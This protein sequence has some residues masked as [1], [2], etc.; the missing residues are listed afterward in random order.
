MRRILYIHTW[1]EKST[2]AE[3]YAACGNSGTFRSDSERPPLLKTYNY[4][5][6]WVAVFQRKQQ[7][8]LS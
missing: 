5:K 1:L 4:V 6:I 3:F 2:P 7:K 8:E